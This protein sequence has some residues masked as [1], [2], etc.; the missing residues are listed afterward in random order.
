M[1]LTDIRMPPDYDAEGV[2]VAADLRE[3]HPDVGV[4][5]LSQ[6]LEPRSVLELLANNPAIAESLGLSASAPSRSTSTRSSRSWSCPSRRTSAAGSR[7]R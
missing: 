6:Y 2:R 5:V 3:T 4:V 7:R 1:V